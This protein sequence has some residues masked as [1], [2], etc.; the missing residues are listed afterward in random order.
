MRKRR[1]AAVVARNRRIWYGEPGESCSEVLLSFNN[2]A[3]LFIFRLSWQHNVIVLGNKL[4]LYSL[5]R[6]VSEVERELVLVENHQD[7]VEITSIFSVFIHH[8]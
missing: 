1:E 5:I 6:R 3:L 8:A 2:P 4:R 7:V